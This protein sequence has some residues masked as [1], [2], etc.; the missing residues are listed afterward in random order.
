MSFEEK[1]LEGK[2][3]YFKDGAQYSEEVFKI[4]KEDKSQGNYTFSS[5]ILSRVSTGEFLKVH[6]DYEVSHQFDPLNVRIKRSLGNRKSTERYIVDT[7]ER[8]VFYSFDGADGHNEMEQVVL[9]NAYIATPAFLTS[10]LMTQM[11]KLNA[12]Q[13]TQY[14]IITS[15]NL[16]TYEA[17][18]LQSEVF[19]DLKS[20]K[21]IEIEI[22]EKTLSATHCTMFEGEK[23]EF[24]TNFYLSKYFSIPYRAVFPNSIEVR[25]ENLKTFDVEY[26][27]MFK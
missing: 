11:K 25:V 2:Y 15:S 27:N 4:T 17:P 19:V 6:V 13:T 5:E 16:W 23:N 3:L 1:L 9:A 7:K 24:E 26:K 12:S 10:T 14:T 22:N 18:F 8:N 21:P 20:S